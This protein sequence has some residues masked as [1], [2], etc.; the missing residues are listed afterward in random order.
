MYG[1]GIIFKL[2]DIDQGG[3]RHSLFED[4]FFSHFALI[5]SRL[6]TLYHALI[7]SVVGLLVSQSLRQ[8]HQRQ[9][10]QG[11]VCIRPSFTPSAPLSSL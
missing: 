9:N 3:G 7:K 5:D 4:F 2:P 1:I 6:Q 8:P 10:Q 11:P